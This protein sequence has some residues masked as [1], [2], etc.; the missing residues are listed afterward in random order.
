MAES[1]SPS[2]EL[3]VM[4]EVKLPR[5]GLYVVGDG[6]IVTVKRVEAAMVSGMVASVLS[7]GTL[8]DH[9]ILMHSAML[10]S[11]DESPRMAILIYVHCQQFRVRMDRIYVLTNSRCSHISKQRFIFPISI[12]TPSR[13]KTID[14]RVV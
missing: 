8:I 14:T 6:G 13:E 2:V 11:A 4:L 7:I 5:W 12:A 10:K 9:M 3:L 1:S